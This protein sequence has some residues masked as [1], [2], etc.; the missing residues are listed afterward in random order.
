MNKPFIFTDEHRKF[1]V[2]HF[3]K[4]FN[5]DLTEMFNREFNLNVSENQIA[6]FKYRNGLKSNLPIGS[7]KPRHKHR[8]KPLG[9]QRIANGHILVKIENGWKKL[10]RIVWEQHN[11]EIPKG[12]E[13]MFLDGNKTNCDISNLFLVTKGELI[14]TIKHRKISDIPEVTKANVLITKINLAIN[15]RKRGK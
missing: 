10:S 4:T 14:Q 12:Y 11:G 7:R 5:D 9:T 1:I 3:E 13:V 15:E 6:Q 2:N 8:L